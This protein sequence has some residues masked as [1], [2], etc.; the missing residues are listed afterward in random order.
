[1]PNETTQTHIKETSE[2]VEYLNLKLAFFGLP[3]VWSCRKRSDD[4]RIVAAS[5]GNQPTSGGLFVSRRPAH[6]GLF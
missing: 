2:I 1:M 6:P 4:F 3:D 5:A